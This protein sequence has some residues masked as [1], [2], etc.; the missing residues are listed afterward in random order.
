MEEFATAGEAA[1]SSV[2]ALRT[3]AAAAASAVGRPRGVVGQLVSIAR[4]E[5]ARG[6]YRG[7]AA[8]CLLQVSVTGTRFATYGMGKQLLADSSDGGGSDASRPSASSSYLRNTALGLVAGVC[9]AI[10]GCP[11]FALKTSMQAQSDVAALQAGF[12]HGYTSLRS[13]F[14]SIYRESGGLRG[15]FRGVDAF[16][17][18]V[19]MWSAGQLSTY[20][21]FKH[22]LLSAGFADSTPTHLIA[23]AATS[24]VACM[25]M[26]PFD[27]VAARMM[28]QP[29]NPDGRPMFYKS[30]PDCFA[31]SVRNEGILSLYK[32]GLANALRMGPYNILI[33]V[34]YEQLKMLKASFS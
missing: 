34:F 26:T 9:G 33:F 21:A 30:L 2:A 10:C 32:G 25:L 18:R 31:K 15:Y 23:S 4:Y 7:L 1:L 22:S 3:P 27:F 13:A 14:V 20:D 24:V 5:G 17:L 28:N 12:Q 8:A 11:F 16:V 6:L 19:G 29:S